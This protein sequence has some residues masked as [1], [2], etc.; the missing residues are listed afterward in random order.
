MQTSIRSPILTAAQATFGRIK[1]RSMERRAA[2]GWE[3]RPYKFVRGAFFEMQPPHDFHVIVHLG[4]LNNRPGGLLPVDGAFYLNIDEG[5]YR[6]GGNHKLTL[7]GELSLACWFRLRPPPPKGVG[8]A[9][10]AL[11]YE[12]GSLYG[13]SKWGG[14]QRAGGG[15]VLEV[16]P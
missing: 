1:G 11:T 13:I 8:R 16:T 6:N 9:G 5:P 2:A 14:K 7:S 10:V 15:T 12:G 3:R 4:D